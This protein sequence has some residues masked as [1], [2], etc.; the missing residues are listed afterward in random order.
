[1]GVDG[2]GH[3]IGGAG[4]P[5]AMVVGQVSLKGARGMLPALR[6]LGLEGHTLGEAS[7]IPH[8]SSDRGCPTSVRL[9][10][11]PPLE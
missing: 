6:W 10:L 1:M 11:P 9:T 7:G 5:I 8:P 4:L 2:M 3:G